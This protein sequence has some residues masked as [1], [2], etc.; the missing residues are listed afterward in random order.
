MKLTARFLQKL[1]SDSG[2]AL[3]F[4][5][6]FFLLCGMVGSTVLMAASSDAGKLRSS[7]VEQQRY[8]A[9]TSALRLIADQIEKLQYT[10]RAPDTEQTVA[11]PPSYTYREYTQETGSLDNNELPSALPLLKELDWLFA[12]SF[13][14]APGG[15]S[16]GDDNYITLDPADISEPSDA[17]YDLTLIPSSSAPVLQDIKGLTDT[18]SN[19][20]IVNIRLG[21]ADA[22]KY[23][24]FLSAWYESDTAGRQKIY[25]ELQPGNTPDVRSLDWTTAWE[26]KQIGKGGG[27]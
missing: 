22:D 14:T 2:K 21:K 3:L 23:K 19:A 7:R 24:F 27:P 4:A 8:F 1:H 20:I 6:L 9:L 11:G 17:G 13:P 18:S 15:G 26:L 16:P 5:L 10:G 25:A 12:Q